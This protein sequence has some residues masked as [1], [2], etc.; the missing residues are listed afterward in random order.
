[1]KISI[2]SLLLLLSVLFLVSLFVSRA[3]SR[4]G[5]PALLLFLGVG[6]LFGSDGFGIEF[7]NY[8]I[9]EGIGTLALCIIL[10]SCGLDTKYHDIKPVF[11][12]G[13]VL[14]TVGVMLTALITGLF[15]YYV[16]NPL[17][18]IQITFLEA[19]LLASVMS[20]TD[21]ASVFSI[22]RGKS[23]RLKNNLAPMLEFE[24]GSNDA[25]AY[26]LTV[27]LIA[28]IKTGSTNYGNAVLSF[29]MQFAI[30]G[31]AGFIIGK[32]AVRTFNKIK[33]PNDA[34]YPVLL[35]ACGIFTFSITHFIKG[36]GYLAIYIAGIVIGN[37]KFVHKRSSLNFFDGLAWLSQVGMFLML[38][39]LVNPRE[40][41]PYT[42]GCI[43]IGVFVILGARPLSVI[44]SLLP[45]RKMGKRDKVFISWVGLKGAVPII[46]AIFPLAAGVEHARLIFNVVFF[47][48]LISLLIQGTAVVPIAK[49][50][51]LVKKDTWIKRLRDFNIENIGD[52]KSTITEI[53]I[54]EKILKNG[55]RLM[56]IPLPEH[57]LVTTIKR[58][59]DYFIP[60]GDSVLESGDALLIITN[61]EKAL[62]ETYQNLEIDYRMFAKDELG[63]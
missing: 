51:R 9:A 38:G 14:A 28:L 20:S 46:F 45:F 62:A 63:G 18:P 33:L 57:T 37:A 26:M 4:F 1:M 8:A 40:L 5:V 2:E 44:I 41:L 7:D 59:D 43:V 42:V 36:N 24:S 32:L 13:V 19:L 27:V 25:M 39:L 16:V 6:M 61:D 58:G 47:I 60:K 21:S 56:D 10:F 23:V 17:I 54:D 11:V 52:L 48:T 34:L 31:M 49:M 29:F 35:F 15:I 12:H 55:N 3:S 22:L 50:L 30:G 53:D